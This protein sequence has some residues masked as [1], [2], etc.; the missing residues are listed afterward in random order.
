MGLARSTHEGISAIKKS[1]F[2]MFTTKF[3]E[4]RI[5]E[6]EQ[7]INFYTKLQDL[8][9][10]KAGLRDSL[11]SD[12]IV[13]KILRLLPERFKPKVTSIEKSKDIDTII[14]DELVGSL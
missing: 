8:V 5:E 9:N 3:K 14:V 6:D 12:V 11:T 1:K 2:Q 4:L 7:L 10:S 13:R